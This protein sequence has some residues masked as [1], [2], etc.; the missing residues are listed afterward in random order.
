MKVPG[1]EALLVKDMTRLAAEYGRY[2]Y[3]RIT[4][5]PRREGWP[6][7]HKRIERLWRRE[8]LKVRKK[9]P[10]R[11]RLWLND[12]SCVRLISL[13]RNHVWSYDFVMVRTADGRPVRIL[14]IIDEHTRECLKM[15]VARRLNT[16]DV[17][18]ALW[19]LFLLRGLP[20]HIRSDNGPEF[21]AK[22]FREWLGNAG[23]RTLFIEPGR[24]WSRA[25][26][27]SPSTARCGTGC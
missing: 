8:G 26:M 23:V 20:E 7:N 5:M 3:R 16:K 22:T 14:V 6:V 18:E 17:L 24:P 10:K 15:V 4:S 13:R 2:G 19:D 27:L 12:G 11:G 9:Q 21:A 25:G 1:D